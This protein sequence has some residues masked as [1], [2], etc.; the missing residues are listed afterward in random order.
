[1]PLRSHS[2]ITLLAAAMALPL[3]APTAAHAAAVT[4]DFS[5]SST[6]SSG[7]FYELGSVGTGSF[8]FDDSL[9]PISGNG[10]IGNGIQGTPTVALSFNWFGAAFDLNN[11]KISTLWFTDGVLTDWSLGGNHLPAV[12]GLMRYTCVHSAGTEADFMLSASG[13]GSLND[14]V[15]A[16]V[17]SG[18]GT[19]SWAVQPA[20]VPEPGTLAL[21]GLGVMGIALRRRGDAEASRRAA[22]ARG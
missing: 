3:A 15:H 22:S 5:I 4:V 18:Y 21:L 12:C 9:I 16:G 14:G 13:G 10:H 17:G 1:M 11:A 19:L 20:A 8:T 6:T 2:A 7:S